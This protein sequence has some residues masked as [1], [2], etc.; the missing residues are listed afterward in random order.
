MPVNIALLGLLLVVQPAASWAEG[1]STY[2]A[3]M[4]AEAGIA[5]EAC[6]LAD[7]EQPSKA[8]IPASTGSKT[9]TLIDHGRWV[10]AKE[11]VPID[12]CVA[13]PTSH[14]HAEAQ[15][16]PSPFLTVPASIPLANLPAA[17]A[18]AVPSPPPPVVA[19]AAGYG[20]PAAPVQPPVVRFIAPPP[21]PPVDPAFRSIPPPPPPVDPVLSFAPPLIPPAETVFIDQPLPPAGFVF[22]GAPAPLPADPA[23][24]ALLIEDSRERF[25][26]QGQIGRCRRAVVSSRFPSYRYVTC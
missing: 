17:Y 9:A 20:V 2:A 23:G 24:E 26:R 19:R 16:A 10:C 7:R 5:E 18:A 21:P 25:F 11:G 3:R 14:R 1:L 6:A 15:A 4:C 13:L 12:D 8:I 22:D